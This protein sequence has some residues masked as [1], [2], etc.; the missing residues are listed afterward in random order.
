MTEKEL[1][2]KRAMELLGKGLSL[3]KHGKPNGEKLFLANDGSF[4][5]QRPD[6]YV[7]SIEERKIDFSKYK[8]TGGM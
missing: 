3:R 5:I 2:K 4:C 1:A 8:W 7:F 6:G